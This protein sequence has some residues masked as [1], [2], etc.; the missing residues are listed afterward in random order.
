MER[1][2]VLLILKCQA[3]K[4][5]F[6]IMATIK[7]TT[8]NM[9]NFAENRLFVN[10]K[11]RSKVNPKYDFTDFRETG[12]FNVNFTESDVALRLQDRHFRTIYVYSV[13]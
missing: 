2:D 5:N 9:R 7:V 3:Q 8:E 11:G 12:I 1:P 10:I 13:S 6:L 4:P